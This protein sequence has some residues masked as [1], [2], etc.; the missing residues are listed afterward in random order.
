[1]TKP[2]PIRCHEN[3][4]L[5]RE[6]VAFTSARTGF[7][8]RLV[9]KD[10]FCTLALQYLVAGVP[11]LIFKGGTCLAKVH[12]GFY[13]LSEDLDFAINTPLKTARSGRSRLAEPAKGAVARLGDQLPVFRVLQGLRGSNNSTQYQALVGYPSLFSDQQETIKI[14]IGLREPLLGSE[15]WGE[16]HTLLLN[17]LINA[18]M[19]PVLR[20]PCLAIEEAMAEKLRAALSRREVA[21]RDFYDMDYAVRRLGFD[22]RLPGFLDLTRKKLSIPGNE[23]I[24]ASESRLA[25]LRPQV[26]THLKPVLRGQDL[27]EFNVERAFALVSGLAA[28]VKIT[29]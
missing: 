22:V 24:D 3:Q 1:M 10:Y 23:A 15:V 13:R 25:A 6:A 7:V 17:P 4:A 14:E 27:A 29:S 16:A 21:I 12:A 5:F 8:P 18:P 19:V 2:E 28:R 20:V 11:N 26:D 9:E